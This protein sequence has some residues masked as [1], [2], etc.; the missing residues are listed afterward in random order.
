MKQAEILH[1]AVSE[2]QRHTK[3]GLRLCLHRHAP[4]SVFF[5][6]RPKIFS[7]YQYTIVEPTGEINAI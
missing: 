6:S 2:Q 1:F 4:K 7:L 3:A 5:A